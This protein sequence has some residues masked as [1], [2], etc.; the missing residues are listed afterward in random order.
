MIL[1]VFLFILVL[2]SIYL[3]NY[4][5]YYFFPLHPRYIFLDPP[6]SLSAEAEMINKKTNPGDCILCN[7]GIRYRYLKRK[8]IP[9]HFHLFSYGNIHAYYYI[10]KYT[11]RKQDTWSF[12]EYLLSCNITHIYTEY[13]DPLWRIEA[14]PVSQWGNRTLYRLK[15]GD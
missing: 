8:F 9:D 15:G 13:L 11:R 6:R 1:S 14:K 2:S 10:Y 7:A 3:K 4:R 5:G 12:E